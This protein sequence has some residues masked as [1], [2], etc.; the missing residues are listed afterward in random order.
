MNQ[1]KKNPKKIKKVNNKMKKTVPK[2]NHQDHLQK[3][4]LLRPKKEQRRKN[5]KKKKQKKIKKE[6]KASQ[7]RIKKKNRKKIGWM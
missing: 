5:Q 7:K 1:K 3:Y 2:S 4:K 6:E